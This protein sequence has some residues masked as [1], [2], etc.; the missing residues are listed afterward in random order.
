VVIASG[1][2]RGIVELLAQ[3]LAGGVDR[4]R[5]R[6]DPAEAAASALQ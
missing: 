1:E 2:Y 5:A 4:R 6:Q 3:R